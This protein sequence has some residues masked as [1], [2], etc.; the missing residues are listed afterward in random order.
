M[1]ALNM[2]QLTIRI[3]RVSLLCVSLVK[4]MDAQAE[5]TPASLS[6]QDKLKLEVSAC[7]PHG[8]YMAE[9][10]GWAFDADKGKASFADVKCRPHGKM[11][12]QPLYWVTQCVRENEGWGCSPAELETRVP[13]RFAGTQ[14]LHLLDVRPGSVAPEKAHKALQ[15]AAKYNYFQGYSLQQALQSP[16]NMGM[17]ERPDLVEV[18]CRDWTISISFW[19][20]Q[21]AR[22]KSCPRIIFM[23]PKK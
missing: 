16:C 7:Q 19:C 1:Q 6:R 3:A 4:L 5:V 10:Q 20:P 22:D 12:G 8:Q 9:A 21:Q 2:S 14:Q 15:Q 11:L 18:S 17:G 13:L 23:A